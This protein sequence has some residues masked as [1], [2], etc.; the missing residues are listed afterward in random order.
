MA[1]PLFQLGS[2]Q[3]DL[4]NG[5]PQTLERSADYRWEGQDRILRDPAYQFVGPGNQEIT[6][7]G[8]LYPGLSGSASTM[9]TLRTLAAAG[10]PQMLTN[11]LGK[12]FGKWAITSLRE[13]LAVFAPGG[14]ARQISFSVRLVRYGEDNPGTAA[15]P[16][17]VALGST[18]LNPFAAG[19][20]LA[21]GLQAAGSAF[22]A[23]VWA[24]NLPFQLPS[25]ATA[26]KGA[27]FNLSQ[28]ANIAR[29]VGNGN[30]VEAALG[31]FG[32]AGLNIDRTNVWTQLGV[33]A[34]G[35]LQSMAQ[36][37]GPPAMAVLLEKLRPASYA[38]LQQLGGSIGGAAGLRN[39]VKDAATIS[40]VLDVDPHVTAAVRQV[41]N[42]AMVL[43]SSYPVLP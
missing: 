9:E 18:P 4:P 40:T 17:S 35:I 26:A 39:L 12:V 38:T 14:G 42:G 28:L 2:F 32:V 33:N 21:S 41:V 1:Q 25:L 19:L 29:S 22:D 24:R 34:A 3:F 11:G 30:Y 43:T 13:G 27:G 15:A 37:K 20:S 7:D 16:S 36:G 8:M 6:L 31:A 5:V 10:E 23:T